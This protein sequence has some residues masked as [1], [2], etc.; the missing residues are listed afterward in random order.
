MTDN[1]HLVEKFEGISFSPSAEKFILTLPEEIQ[2]KLAIEMVELYGKVLD[3]LLRVRVQTFVHWREASYLSL[4]N[5]NET[6]FKV[7]GY[8]F[9]VN[10][11]NET[12]RWHVRLVKSPKDSANIDETSLPT[13]RKS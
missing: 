7:N 2:K 4:L 1:I 6:L 11:C 5:A 9:F 12:L 13:R 8:A 10:I 3:Y